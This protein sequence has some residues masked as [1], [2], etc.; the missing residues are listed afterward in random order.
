MTQVHI[1]KVLAVVG[2]TASGKT[3]LAIDLAKAFQGEVISADS[4]QVYRGL[5]IGTAKVTRDEMQGIPHH[6]IDIVDIDTIYTGQDFVHDATA[7]ISS[8]TKQEK[9][10]IIAGGTFFYLELLRG[11]MQAAPVPPNPTL[12]KELETKSTSELH[13]LLTA[14][15]PKRAARIDQHNR[16]RLIRALEIS[17]AL[18]GVPEPSKDTDTPFDMFIVALE[19]DKETL[20]QRFRARA[21][22]WLQNGFR[23]EVEDVLAQGVS[24]SRLAEIGFEYTLML[25]HIDGELTKDEFIQRFIE[26]NWQYAKKQLTWLKRDPSI[27]WVNPQAT[28]EVTALTTAINVWLS[29]TKADG[30]RT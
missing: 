27:H 28:V 18:G 30:V 15:A 4:R 21:V 22:S 12:R 8:I 29:T 25:S 1:P 6:L 23:N 14:T 2:P 26:K 13:E 16:R 3:G 7:A 11:T 17:E 10:P 20:R 24:R 5:D 19:V 9:L